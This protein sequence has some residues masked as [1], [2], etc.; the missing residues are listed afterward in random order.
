MLD[1]RR[2]K[3]DNATQVAN[4]TAASLQESF[5]QVTQASDLVEEIA[6]DSNRQAEDI[7]KVNQGWLQ[8]DEV[9]RR[10]TASAQEIAGSIEELADQA[11][12]LPS[13]IGRF[14]L[15]EGAAPC[16][17]PIPPPQ[18]SL[19]PSEPAQPAGEGSGAFSEGVT[20]WSESPSTAG[21]VPQGDP[22]AGP[23]TGPGCELVNPKV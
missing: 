8:I 11:D 6:A 14:K 19:E 5:E 16:T 20:E 12:E 3:V 9:T 1:A 10:N 2:D 13:L 23:L 22:F 4:R 21:D 17:N 18:P 15:R 7:S